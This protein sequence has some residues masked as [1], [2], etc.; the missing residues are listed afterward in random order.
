[1]D[2]FERPELSKG[3]V[4]YIAPGEYMVRPPQP[5]CFV[6]L[7][8]VTYTAVSTGMLDTVVS[9]IKE[10]IQSG[11]MCG[12]TR[13]QIA[14]LTFDTSLHF[15]KLNANQSTP[16]MFV[17]SDLQDL[18]LPLA[19]DLL[20]NLSENED[21]VL[22][23]LDAL[24]QMFGET[25]TNES[26]LGS[27]I[28][29]AHLLMKQ[30][31]GKML[32]FG[33]SI[34]SVGDMALKSSRDNPKL[35]GTDREVEILRPANDSWKDY[36]A[37]LTKA[38]ISVELFVGPHTYVDL[39][40]IAPIAKYT[41]GDLRYYP[42]FHIQHSGL[43]LKTELLHVL[44]RFMGWEAVMRIRVSKGW[45]ITK[46]Y[47]HVFLRGADLLVVPNCHTD[48][49]FAIGVD[50]DEN[51]SPDDVFCVQSALLYTNSDGERRIRVN[52]WAAPTTQ[53]FPDILG[54]IDVQAT[55]FMLTQGAMEHSLTANLPDGRN[56]LQTRCQQIVQSGNAVPNLEALQFLPLYILGMLKSPAFRAT[57]EVSADARIAAWT[58]LQ[59]LAVSQVSAYFYP[60]M[61]ALHNLPPDS[62]LQ[63]D[64]GVSMPPMLNLT[65]E[66]MTQDGV[67]LIENGEVMFVWL[68]RAVDAGFVN[69]A[70][71]SESFEAIENANAELVL[72]TRGD[73]LS[74]KIG[75]VLG[76]I[77]SERPVPYMQLHVIRQGEPQEPRFF[78]WL[79]E[80]RTTGLQSTYTEFLQRMGYKP[81]QA[82]AP[83]QHAYMPPQQAHMPG[84]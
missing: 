22:N 15:Y 51:V 13:T 29:G 47:G 61:L 20:V 56:Q 2:R 39:A 80:D 34:P 17:V 71:G 69:A 21:M 57:N 52:T 82:N 72:G 23:L 9:T 74:E 16:Q 70:F 19:D 14:I 7:I 25:Q 36:A 6:F 77:R 35:L 81:T 55:T 43:K 58:R 53:N 41:S 12:G 33:A 44:T 62:G 76:Q 60:R 26:C 73:P 54:S 40:S 50:I 42:N 30:V 1:M 63:A 24:P 46:F 11:R 84:R 8:E 5:P 67:Y 83:Q 59:S 49:T 66:S 3:A 48:Q 4:E 32:V 37:E 10:A 27:A 45:K 75:A 68:G 28:K 64:G 78:A 79:I 18:F 31:G 65:S 38:Q